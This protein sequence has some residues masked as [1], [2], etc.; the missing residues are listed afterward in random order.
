MEEFN[1]NTEEERKI[2]FS[3]GLRL[4]QT[5]AITGSGEKLPQA[6]A[7]A[8]ELRVA[9]DEHRAHPLW[10]SA[11]PLCPRSLSSLEESPSP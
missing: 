7:S 8:L 2:I 6:K 9:P 1:Y 4:N 11:S 3:V 10:A 5:K